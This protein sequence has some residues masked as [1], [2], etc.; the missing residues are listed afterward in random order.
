MVLIPGHFGERDQKYLDSLEIWCWRRMEKISWTKN[1]KY[2]EVRLLHTVKSKM[3][4][5]VQQNE[6]RMSVMSI[7]CVGNAY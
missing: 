5:Y 7:S 2:D 6:G 1:V 3:N 4:I